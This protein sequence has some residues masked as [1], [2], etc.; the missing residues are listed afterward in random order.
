MFAP[1]SNSRSIAEPPSTECEACT[2]ICKVHHCTSRQC[3]CSARGSC[4]TVWWDCFLTNLFDDVDISFAQLLGCICPERGIKVAK[5]LLRLHNGHPAYPSL[6]SAIGSEYCVT[7]V[8]S[9]DNGFWYDKQ[10]QTAGRLTLLDWHGG[11]QCSSGQRRSD[12]SARLQTPPLQRVQR[13][14]ARYL[15]IG[16]FLQPLL[17]QRSPVGP[18]PTMT[19]WRSRFFSC[20]LWPA[21]WQQRVEVVSTLNT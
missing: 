20:S 10:L 6:M 5:Q 4:Y 17:Q 11:R 15:P 13:Q 8:T 19:V 9:G 7:S 14:P 1:A 3:F 2:R 18:P 16:S 12:R 21:K